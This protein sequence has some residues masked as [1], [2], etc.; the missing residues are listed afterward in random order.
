MGE[1][2]DKFTLKIATRILRDGE[3]DELIEREYPCACS[4]G[5]GVHRVK[6]TDSDMGFSVI[7]AD[8]NNC[9]VTISRERAAKVFVQKGSSYGMEYT[10]PYG[11]FQ[12][13]FSTLDFSL[14]LDGESGGCI[15]YTAELDFGDFVQTNC[16]K[17]VVAPAAK[18]P[19][20]N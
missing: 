6:Y 13:K 16:V 4:F 1:R 10:T 9:S 12:I 20:V 15:E 11:A 5:G 7:K 18:L 17:M 14:S 19:T 3:E 8:E 2:A